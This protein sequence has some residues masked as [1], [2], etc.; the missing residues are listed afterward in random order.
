MDF[1]E[2]RHSGNV[3]L[4]VTALQTNFSSNMFPKYVQKD[5]DVPGFVL[6]LTSTAVSGCFSTLSSK[7]AQ[8]PPCNSS[9]LRTSFLASQSPGLSGASLFA[10]PL[11]PGSTGLQDRACSV[12]ALPVTEAQCE[13]PMAP[14]WFCCSPVL[15]LSGERVPR[16]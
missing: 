1:D 16:G 14:L 4:V 3:I 2:P 5:K 13:L 7:T 12:C 9:L 8:P 10:L 15:L 11:S 6:F